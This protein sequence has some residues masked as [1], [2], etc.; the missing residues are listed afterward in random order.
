MSERRDE[1][2]TQRASWVVRV[3]SLTQQAGDDLSDCTTS[4]QR[5]DMMWPLAVEAWSL[6]GH[7]LPDYERADT[8]VRVLN[9]GFGE[10]HAAP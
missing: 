4:E 10:R 7:R 9:D 1:R 3:S 5:L 8:P 2:A 6:S